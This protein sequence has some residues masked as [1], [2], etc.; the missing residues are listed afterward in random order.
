[1]PGASKTSWA[2]LRVGLMAIVALIILGYLVFLMAGSKGLFE[3]T[4]PLYT[5]LDDSASL[6]D[7]APVAIN[8]INAGKVV[9]TE[10]SG[11]TEPNHAVRV[12]ME[13]RTEMLKE[14]PVDSLAAISA[15]NLL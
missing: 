9:R 13:I 3:A 15:A 12:V 7:G 14:I 5:F 8:G 2:Q 10:L 1:M 4:A 6:A 11:S